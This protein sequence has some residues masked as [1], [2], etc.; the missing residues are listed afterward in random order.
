MC[1]GN[2]GFKFLPPC[3]AVSHAIHITSPCSLAHTR[4]H[5]PLALQHTGFCASLFYPL[6]FHY[7]FMP[8]IAQYTEFMTHKW[9]HGPMSQSC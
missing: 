1:S 7:V 3:L 2:M 8:D 5:T 6:H 4:V 9:E